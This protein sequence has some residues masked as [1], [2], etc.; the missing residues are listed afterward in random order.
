LDQALSALQAQLSASDAQRLSAWTGQLGAMA[1]E[2]RRGQRQAD[3]QAA[4]RQAQTCATLEHTAQR[5]VAQAEA[6]AGRTLA[7][8]H[9]LLHTAA[10]A[11]RA[12]AELV[13][14]LRDKLSDSLARDNAMLDERSR[15]LATL[16]TLLDAVQH[17]T[18]GQRAAIDTLLTST[19]DWLERSGA[20]FTEKI[21]AG[22]ARMESV[23]AQL[24]AS[25]V[26]VASLG[27]A[28]GAAVDGFSRSSEQ[29]M[30]HLQRVDVSLGRSMAR[31]DEQLA[32]Y[33]A[34]AREVIDLSLASQKQIVDDL[35]RIAGRHTAQA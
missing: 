23:A 11:P 27:E 6:Q 1:A 16:N 31:S 34:Q 29:L 12:A 4:A 33:V 17:S 5:I 35:Q 7:E 21:D 15:M 3:E 20:R 25:A 13:G 22:S 10:E 30:A 19:A 8:I 28:F 9:T 2:L 18:T 32:Y 24:S 26:D 14:Q